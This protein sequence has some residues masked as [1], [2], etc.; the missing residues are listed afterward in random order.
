MTGEVNANPPKPTP[1]I[2]QRP[3]QSGSL[4]RNSQGPRTIHG[5]HDVFHNCITH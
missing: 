3:H 2:P 4:P 5:E 1:Q